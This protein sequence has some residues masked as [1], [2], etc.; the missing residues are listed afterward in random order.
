MTVATSVKYIHIVFVSQIPVCTASEL[1]TQLVCILC[2][3]GAEIH[4][5]LSPSHFWV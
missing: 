4:F 3:T 5:Y 2:F 1:Q